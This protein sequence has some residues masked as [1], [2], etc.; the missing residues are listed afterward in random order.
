MSSRVDGPNT[1]PSGLARC[2]LG[3]TTGVPE[4]TT[5]PARPWYPI[6]RCRQFG[7]SGGWPGRRILPTFAAWCSE[8]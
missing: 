7:S 1:G 5:V 8:E 3:R 4:T 6:G 2:P